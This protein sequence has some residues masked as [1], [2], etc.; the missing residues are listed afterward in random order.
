MLEKSEAD[1]S[2]TTLYQD[3]A[4]NDYIFHWQSQ[5]SSSAN[6]GKGKTYVDQRHNGKKILLFVRERN[7][8]EYN[9]TMGYVFLGEVNYLAHEGAKPM[10]IKWQLNEPIPAYLWQDT[11]KM[12]VA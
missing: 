1:Y 5:H 9:N 2:P 10:N 4:V 8:D 11:A 7:N 6:S 12:A 3:Y